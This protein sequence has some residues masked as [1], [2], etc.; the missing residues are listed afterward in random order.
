MEPNKYSNFKSPLDWEVISANMKRGMEHLKQNQRSGTRNKCALSYHVNTL[1]DSCLWSQ[2][3]RLEVMQQVQPSDLHC[4]LAETQVKEHRP[5]SGGEWA[6]LGAKGNRSQRG[7]GGG[8]ASGMRR[9]DML[10]WPARQKEHYLGA[11]G[12][13]Y[14]C[15]HSNLISPHFDTR[16]WLKLH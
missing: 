3:Q 16:T 6:H 11:L 14:H 13:E 12:M 1:C 15:L 7:G 2:P 10:G 4:G 5:A 8:G 9:W